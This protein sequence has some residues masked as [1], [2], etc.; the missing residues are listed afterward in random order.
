MIA[1]N[2]T[3]VERVLGGGDARV[4]ASTA[5][6][7]SARL[8]SSVDGC[9]AAA[10]WSTCIA[11]VPCAEPEGVG[12]PLTCGTA[13]ADVEVAS[14]CDTDTAAGAG[15]VVVAAIDDAA[16]CALSFARRTWL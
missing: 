3:P 2:E 6:N 4:S 16:A 7:E 9:A 11:L 8:G 5:G 15:V 13:G 10:A 12:A 1:P 14:T